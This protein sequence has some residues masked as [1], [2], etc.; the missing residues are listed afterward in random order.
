MDQGETF[1]LII[2]TVGTGLLIIES[3]RTYYLICKYKRLSSPGFSR[4]V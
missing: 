1:L 3:V 2:A 4:L